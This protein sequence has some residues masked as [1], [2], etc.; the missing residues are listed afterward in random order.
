MPY[1]AN[2]RANQFRSSANQNTYTGDHS[3]LSVFSWILWQN[4]WRVCIR[5]SWLR[6]C[7]STYCTIS[8]KDK[9]DY[10]HFLIPDT[11]HSYT[12]LRSHLWRS[13]YANNCDSLSQEII[14]GHQ[15]WSAFIDS[16]M[17]YLTRSQKR[18]RISCKFCRTIVTMGAEYACVYLAVMFTKG[19]MHYNVGLGQS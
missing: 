16:K 19:T 17:P 12:Y 14:Y 15:Q 11:I 8:Q 6:K 13:R 18:S 7:L 1:W 9:S 10:F 2:K 3:S 5:H 4:H